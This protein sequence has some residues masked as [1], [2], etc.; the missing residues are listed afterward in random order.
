MA[1]NSKNV[2]VGA[3]DQ[4]TTGAI[5]SAPEGTALP[6]SVVA[7]LDEDFVDAGYV[8]EDGVTLTPDRSTTSIKDWSRAE[9]RRLLDEFTAEMSWEHLELSE[10]AL[11]D[12]F[13]D[14]NVTVTA[15]TVSTGTQIASVLNA[16]D[17][18]VKARVF[19]M[20]DGAR[21]IR[22]VVPRGQV[23]AQGEITFIANDA[24][25]L[26]ITLACLPD[27]SGNHVYIYTDDGVFS[28]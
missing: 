11:K 6:T 23:S 1:V 19:N 2:F 12:Y 5:F 22:I 10:E 3:P 25:K 8:G 27:A 28:A 15:A 20:K 16:D 4:A 18:P 14:D 17:L 26:P 13:G 7:V 24:V 9:I 21:K